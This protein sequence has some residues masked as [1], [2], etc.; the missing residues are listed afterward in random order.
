VTRLLVEVFQVFA[1]GIGAKHL[2]A[3]PRLDATSPEALRCSQ[4]TILVLPPSPA[5]FPVTH[6]RRQLSLRT[7]HAYLLTG[8]LGGIGLSI[9]RYLALH[10]ARHLVFLSPSAGSRPNAV[11]ELEALGCVVACVPGRAEST[12]DVALALRTCAAWGTPVS[13][14][15]HAAMILRDAYFTDVSAADWKAC[16]APKVEGARVLERALAPQEEEAQQKLDFFIVLSSLSG[17]GGMVGQANYAAA[18]AWLDAFAQERR[19]RGLAACSLDLGAV[20][21]VGV[22]AREARRRRAIRADDMHGLREREVL[23]AV[24]VAITGGPRSWE[25]AGYVASGQMAVGLQL[26]GEAAA[27]TG[28]VRDARTLTLWNERGGAE[29]GGAPIAKNGSSLKESLARWEANPA[30]LEQNEAREFLAREIGAVM[31][32]ALMRGDEDIDLAAP[33]EALGVDSLVSIE[34]RNWLRQSIGVSFTVAEIR[35]AENI[36]ALGRTA[37][38]RLGQRY[39]SNA[40]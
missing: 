38:M 6:L 26:S 25:D 9:A 3:T 10:G 32:R 35:A 7:T 5:A 40:A 24:E 20:E 1:K 36:I 33:L 14:V 8:G 13:G 21:G 16:V 37:T 4:H 34:L 23:D 30:L 27:L 28:W 22:L 11:A 17:L 19:R 31:T 29:A 2:L 12:A 18:N 39:K 15:I